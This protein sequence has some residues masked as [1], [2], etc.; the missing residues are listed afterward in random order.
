MGFSRQEYWSGLPFP[1]PGV[2]LNPGIELR[3]PALQANSL[4]TELQYFI[5]FM[6]LWMKLYFYFYLFCTI[7]FCLFYLSLA[8]LGLC[9]FEWAFSSCDELG[10]VSSCSAWA[11]HC[12]DFFCCGGSVVVVQRLSCPEACGIFLD[13]GSKL[14]R[15][16]GRRILKH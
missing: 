12:G 14:Y 13:Q 4:L 6:L 15:C 7:Y 2:L 16:I 5:L 11:S 8:A 9:C 10:L 1:S 3:S